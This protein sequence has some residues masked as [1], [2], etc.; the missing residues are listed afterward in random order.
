MW[1]RALLSSLG[2]HE[3]R[4]I[5]FCRTVTHAMVAGIMAAT[6]AAGSSQ[7]PAT[8]WS[9]LLDAR[10]AD[11]T[12]RQKALDAFCRMYWM[13][14]YAF[15]RRRGHSPEDAEDLTQS[16]FARMLSGDRLENISTDGSKGRLRSYLLTALGNFAAKQWTRQAPQRH[17]GIE[18]L[19]SLDSEAAEAAYLSEPADHATPER[20][21]EKRWAMAWLDLCIKRLR[22]E[23]EA[24]GKGAL[25]DALKPTLAL[26]GAQTSFQTIAEATG[27]SEGAARVAAHRLRQ[28]LRAIL[29]EEVAQT[30]QNPA[31]VA[32]EMRYLMTVVAEGA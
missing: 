7:L 30:V 16:F 17:A 26:T 13:P 14:F 22:E 6:T 23:Y 9:V 25:F 3:S 10:S 8:R 15:L 29:E 27:M 5:H 32:D 4:S 18:P 19:V 12:T 31:D 11:A 2:M 1:S 28:H 20:L 24:A 21:F